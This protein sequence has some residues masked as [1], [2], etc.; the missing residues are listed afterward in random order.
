MHAASLLLA[1]L[2]FAEPKPVKLRASALLGPP[3][4]PTTMSAPLYENE[5]YGFF[6][7]PRFLVCRKTDSSCR[8][9]AMVSTLNAKLGCYPCD[10][11]PG[12][13]GVPRLA[14]TWDFRVFDTAAYVPMP[15]VAAERRWFPR[16]VTYEPRRGAFTLYLN[17]ELPEPFGTR[18][19]ILVRDLDEAFDAK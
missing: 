6:L 16:R 7:E 8:A 1:V 15:I 19:E 17:P 4:P 18:L 14:A 10:L 11:K 13:P 9:I 2:L 3:L 5:R 12:D